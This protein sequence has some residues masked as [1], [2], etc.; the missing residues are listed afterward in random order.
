MDWV[1]SKKVIVEEGLDELGLNDAPS[2]V[3]L[4]LKEYPCLNHKYFVR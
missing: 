4:S 1:E 2:G 3:G